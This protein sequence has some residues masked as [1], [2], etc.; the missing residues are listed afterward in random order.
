MAE[1]V[2]VNS[3]W[4]VKSRPQP[5]RKC[6]CERAERDRRSL[7]PA[8]LKHFISIWKQFWVHADHRLDPAQNRLSSEKP[9]PRDAGRPPIT[10][11]SITARR[12]GRETEEM[13]D[14]GPNGIAGPFQSINISAF[15]SDRREWW[16]ELTHVFW[17]SECV[18]L[19]TRVC[20]LQCEKEKKKMR[21]ANRWDSGWKSDNLSPVEEKQQRSGHVNDVTNLDLQTN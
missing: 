16:E 19:L 8:L 9:I 4:R 1:F 10:Q 2:A 5:F 15:P 18:Y 12:I 14:A 13:M 11:H 20:I 21:Q 3:P 17:S 7:S 6:L